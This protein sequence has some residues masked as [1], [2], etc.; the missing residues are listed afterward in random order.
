MTDE[1]KPL[2]NLLGIDELRRE[3]RRSWSLEFDLAD[4]LT[5]LPEVPPVSVLLFL[6]SGR[7]SKFPGDWEVGK[8]MQN[9]YGL[10]KVPPKTECELGAGVWMRLREK[11]I[12]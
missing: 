10:E 1:L 11:L 2:E 5:E 12:K 8:D 6:G 7:I 4:A 3:V 9:K